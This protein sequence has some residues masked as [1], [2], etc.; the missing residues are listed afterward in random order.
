MYE[1]KT[2]K[3]NTGDVTGEAGIV[4]SLRKRDAD[5]KLNPACFILFA[6]WRGIQLKAWLSSSLFY[7]S[8]SLLRK[9]PLRFPHAADKGT[10][11]NLERIPAT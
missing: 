2:V 5:T 3:H 7:L 9:A 6:F 11:G 10:G 1:N 4:A 8:G